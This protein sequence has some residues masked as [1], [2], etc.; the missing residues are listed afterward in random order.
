MPRAKRKPVIESGETP[1][2]EQLAQGG[3]ERKFI[4]HV[5]SATK[6]MAHVRESTILEKWMREGG[7][8]FDV[9]A[10]EVI[11]DFQFYWH[12]MGSPKLCALYGERLPRGDSDGVTQADAAVQIEHMKRALGKQF[13]KLYW[14]VFENCVR[15]LEPAGVAG[16]RMA[17][18]T[19]GQIASARHIVGMIASF[20]AAKLGY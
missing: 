4:T 18:N 17:K 8:G 19:A 9:G 5:E 7:V 2:P 16:S 20:I 6:A 15:H 10:C 14:D 1:T 13:P 3:Y 12:R 11:R